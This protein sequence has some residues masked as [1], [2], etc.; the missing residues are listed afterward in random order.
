MRKF[1]QSILGTGVTFTKLCKFRDTR[2]RIDYERQEVDGIVTESD[3][4]L[5]TIRSWD[6]TVHSNVESSELIPWAE[7]DANP[8]TDAM[9]FDNIED[10]LSWVRTCSV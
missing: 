10:E 4:Y 9:K 8:D 3:G 5:C 7:A 6:G 2:G 1:T